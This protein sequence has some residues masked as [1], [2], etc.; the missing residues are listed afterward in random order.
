MRLISPIQ[1][2]VH[3]SEVT[4][5]TA[6]GFTKL[7]S[8][9]EGIVRVR[10][11]ASP[12]FSDRPSLIIQAD[13]RT[14]APMNVRET[15]EALVVSTSMVS[16]R[17]DRQT[18]AFTYLDGSGQLMTKE[19][20]RGGKT[21]EPV[22]VVISVFDDPGEALSR[23][24]ADGVRIDALPSRQV[25]DR[26]AFHTKLEFEWAPDEALYGLGSHEEGMMN[27]RRQHQYLYQQNMKTVVPILVSTRG[28]GILFD[29]Y[30]LI[31]FH[32][33]AFGSYV[34][35]DVADEL[36][37]YFI[38]GPEFDQI[39][40]GIRQLTGKAP[41]FPRWT[42]GYIQ[43]KERYTSQDELIGVVKACYGTL[44]I[45]GARIGE[46]CLLVQTK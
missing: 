10:F 22:A 43:S 6:G 34:W 37:Y 46:H 8:Y 2:T 9:A 1:P 20:N 24:S 14:P 5:E 31:T 42:F 41:M 4:L 29:S 13:A 23:Q 39:V 12:E 18:G 16:I 21:L 3:T 30:S 33:D 40:Q 38:Y 17:I 36:D 35:T 26:Q 25:I 27:L 45:A 44:G 28:Y 15:A 7:V 11:A 19:P 32:D